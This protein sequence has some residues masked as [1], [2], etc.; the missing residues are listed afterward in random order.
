MKYFATISHPSIRDARTITIN[1][2]LE[3]AKRRAVREFGDGFRD[4][5]IVILDERNDT[6]SRKVIGERNWRDWR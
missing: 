5:V 6:I 2:S 1:G 3:T 4:H